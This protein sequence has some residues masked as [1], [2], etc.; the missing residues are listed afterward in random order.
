MKKF[1]LIPLFLFLLIAIFETVGIRFN[2]TESMPVGFYQ[3]IHTAKIKDGDL[4]A[5]CLPN[6]IAIVGLK[7]YYLAR[8]S[9]QNGSTPVLKKI[10]AVPGDHVVLSNQFIVVNKIFYYAPTQTKDPQN[11]AV[12]KFIS[13]GDYKHIHTYWLYGANDPQYSWDSR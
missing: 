4:A 13:D 8:G 10:V 9:C 11:H 3:K 1:F 2:Y 5:V 7:N 6:A 12:K